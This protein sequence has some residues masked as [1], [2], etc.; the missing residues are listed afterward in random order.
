MSHLM[1]CLI[2]HETAV[3][4]QLLTDFI[5]MFLGVFL[6]LL[7]L[8]FLVVNAQLV[9]IMCQAGTHMYRKNMK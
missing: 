5:L 4:L 9:T 7:M 3:I 2:C 8:L 1:H 6:E